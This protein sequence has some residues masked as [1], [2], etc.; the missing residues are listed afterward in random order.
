MVET[1]RF[2][3][4]W[5]ASTTQTRPL[6]TANTS[7]LLSQISPSL[8][9]KWNNNKLLNIKPLVRKRTK[10]KNHYLLRQKA[11][12]KTL[13][14]E[15]VRGIS[16]SQPISKITTPKQKV[17]SSLM[18]KLIKVM[19]LK[20]LW[21]KILMLK[22]RSTITVTTTTLSPLKVK[23]VLRM[24]ILSVRNQQPKIWLNSWISF[25]ELFKRLIMIK[26]LR[27]QMN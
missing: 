23:L 3:P 25:Q 10:M 16:I 4:N 27:S 7:L 21:T 19:K 15:K 8:R 9:K 13:N 18:L 6:A 17:A 5:I 20:S 24:K 14:I 2:T 26:R 1:T 11:L 22:K 12:Q